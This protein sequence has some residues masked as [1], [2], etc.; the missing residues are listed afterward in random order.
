MSL[1]CLLPLH[2]RIP[3]LGT[4]DGI[5]LEVS[6]VAFALQEL[7]ALNFK[8][9]KVLRFAAL[10]LILL[11][12]AVVLLHEILPLVYLSAAFFDLFNLVRKMLNPLIG[13]PNLFLLL[14]KL[15]QELL[16]F[17]ETRDGLQFEVS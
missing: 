17:R 9:L 1:L 5:K 10:L 8:L 4:P 15:A 3:L 13:L 14:G 16:F 2:E 12:E 11:P 7:L 6:S